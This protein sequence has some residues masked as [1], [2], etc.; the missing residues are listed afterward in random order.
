MVTIQ[1]WFSYTYFFYVSLY[2][3]YPFLSYF[4]SYYITHYISFLLSFF[5]FVSVLVNHLAHTIASIWLI[6]GSYFYCKQLI[7]CE[8]VWHLINC[9]LMT[10]LRKR[11]V[12]IRKYF[13]IK[14]KKN[15]WIMTLLIKLFFNHRFSNLA[16]TYRLVYS[17][18]NSILT[19][20][21]GP[22]TAKH[23]LWYAQRYT[24][25]YF[26]INSKG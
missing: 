8:L 23:G 20:F 9:T 4:L 24:F 25:S 3:S 2:M 12:W 11:I 22:Y 16:M 21:R 6:M 14:E 1:R 18:A 10:S 26:I 5:S 7:D 19:N 13:T 17:I 15:H